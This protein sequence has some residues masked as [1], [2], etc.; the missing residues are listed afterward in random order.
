MDS[1]E[2]RLQSYFHELPFYCVCLNCSERVDIV[3]FT[4]NVYNHD[5][6]VAQ[7]TI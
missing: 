6:L 4:L 7:R 1:N 3:W 2:I 5:F